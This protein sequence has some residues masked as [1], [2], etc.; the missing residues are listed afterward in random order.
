MDEKIPGAA[1]IETKP[2]PRLLE[3]VRLAIRT[4]HYSLRTEQAYLHWTRKFI[5]FHG[6]RHPIEMG[7]VEVGQF[8]QHLA[9]NKNVAAS[10]QNQ[11][12]NALL[13]LYASVLNRPLAKLPKVLRAKRPK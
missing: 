1:T 5:R 12:L 6:K 4:R 2:R 3:Q 11:A 9:F 10:T 8:L 13:F 7:E